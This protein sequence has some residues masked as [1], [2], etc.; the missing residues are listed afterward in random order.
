MFVSSL[1]SALVGQPVGFNIDFRGVE[2]NAVRGV[3]LP[4]PAGAHNVVQSVGFWFMS[5]CSV[6]PVEAH[7]AYCWSL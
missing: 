2:N 5:D 4:L 1:L 7:L 6:N 3:L